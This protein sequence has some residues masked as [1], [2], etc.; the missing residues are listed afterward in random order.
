MFGEVR[1]SLVA[2]S[3][4]PLA[5]SNNSFKFCSFIAKETREELIMCGKWLVRPI[6]SSCLFESIHL[7]FD[8]IV[9]TKASAIAIDSLLLDS[10]SHNKNGAPK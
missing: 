4:P 1:D 8:L 5:K 9:S 10:V 7:N 3:K 2:P 6:N